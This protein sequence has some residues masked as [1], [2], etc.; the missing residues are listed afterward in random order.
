M[1]RTNCLRA[2]QYVTVSGYGCVKVPSI[3]EV[4]MSVG[5]IIPDYISA[6]N[7]VPLPVNDECNPSPEIIKSALLYPL[8]IWWKI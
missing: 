2:T 8:L 3:E 6:F 7:V 4:R 1:Q 5:F